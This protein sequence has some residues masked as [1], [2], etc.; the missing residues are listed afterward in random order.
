MSSG[1]I[2]GDGLTSVRGCGRSRSYNA[3]LPTSLLGCT[4]SSVRR[5]DVFQWGERIA[6][7]LIS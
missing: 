6:C 3:E 4:G 5:D 1:I 2:K 7:P